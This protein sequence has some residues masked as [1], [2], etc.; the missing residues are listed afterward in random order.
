[1]TRT[2]L[3][4]LFMSASLFGGLLTPSVLRA[5]APAER[6][7]LPV[8]MR[9]IQHLTGIP[10]PILSNR[11]LPN[12]KGLAVMRSIPDGFARDLYLSG[13]QGRTWGRV[14][15]QPWPTMGFY[16]TWALDFRL[17][18]LDGGPVWVV[19]KLYSDAAQMWVSRDGGQSWTTRGFPTSPLCTR[20]VLMDVASTPAMSGRLWASLRCDIGNAKSDVGVFFTDDAGVTWGVLDPWTD[21]P[22]E[23]FGAPILSATDANL[24]YRP[25][26]QWIRS[27]DGGAHW[28]RV[29]IPSLDLFIS[30]DDPQILLSD[31][32]FSTELNFSSADGGQTWRA[33]TP[34]PCTASRVFMNAPAFVRGDPHTV[35]ATCQ[36]GELFRS[37]DLGQ[38]WTLLAT[39][40]G[41][42]D[43]VVWDD[44][45]P[46]REYASVQDVANGGNRLRVSI[47]TDG[48]QTWQ[49]I[50]DFN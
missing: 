25:G 8:I 46:G 38:T 2:R 26:V 27:V 34:V 1:M 4:L 43:W 17:L 20:V 3:L 16:S 14:P 40:E 23:G 39:L 29:A 32:V 41:Q 13:D 49:D 10:A 7:T 50:L 30:P 35:I 21:P 42:P 33:W 44:A 9:G 47:S 18:V 6:M 45:V 31:G 36:S 11:L 37:P 15:Q 5:Q 22:T 48:G 19:S 24:M 28:E 12:L